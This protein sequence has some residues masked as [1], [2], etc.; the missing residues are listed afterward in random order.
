MTK[1]LEDNDYEDRGDI[2]IDDIDDDEDEILDEDDLEQG[3]DDEPESESEEDESEDEEDESEDEDDPDDEEDEDEDEDDEEDDIRI[4]KSRLDQVLSQRDSER[5]ENKW[6]REQLEAILQNKTKEV[7]KEEDTPPEYDFDTAEAQYIE[8]ILE[9]DTAEAAKI[10]KEINKARDAEYKYQINEARRMA[11]EEAS[12]E[13]L[14][15]IDETRFTTLLDKYRTE[16]S[17]LNDE[18]DAYNERAVVMA[19]KLMAAY[20]AEGNSKS[21]SLELAV[22]DIVPLFE[23]VNNEKPTRKKVVERESQARKKAAKASRS[24]P[25]TPRSKKDSS[26]VNLDKLK[27]K[28]LMN[29]KIFNSLSAKD[30]AKLRGDIL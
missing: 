6:L 29:D 20:L 5:E 28:D 16:Y 14:N 24:Q 18:N 8:K 11:K 23:K 25:P 22:K 17:F 26:N 13:A 9:G 7:L 27:P 12:G 4:P 1:E 19:N 3:L 2:Y 15:S 21:Q 10:R 30:K